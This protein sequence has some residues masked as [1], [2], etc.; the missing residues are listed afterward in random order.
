MLQIICTYFYFQLPVDLPIIWNKR[1]LKT[2]GYCV[3]KK[4]TK[5]G[6]V[7]MSVSIELSTKVCDSAGIYYSYLFVIFFKSG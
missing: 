3:Y 1:L 2:A 6:N 5:D 7:K 4:K